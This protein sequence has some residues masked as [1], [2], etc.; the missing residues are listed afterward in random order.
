MA[1]S[2]KRWAG[3]A[4]IGFLM[5][6]FLSACSNSGGLRSASEAVS[7]SAAENPARARA[8]AHTELASQ[9]FQAKNMAVALEEVAIAI[10]SDPDYAPVYN[11]R[12]LIQMYL[13]ENEAAN[14]NFQKAL[15]LAPGD[16]EINNNYGWFLCQTDRERES[17][18]YFIAAVK[19]TLYQTPEKSLVNA[20]LCSLKINDLK[21][22]EDYYQKALAMGRSNQAVLLP[23]AHLEYKKGDFLEARHYLAEY[24]RRSVPSSE[25]LWLG[26]RVE[27]KLDNRSAEADLSTQLRRRFPESK[28]ARDLR[29]GNFE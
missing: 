29:R 22:A 20:G 6:V 27:K 28:E 23:L 25:S 3:R 8:K 2:L 1:W 14:E 16:P 24:H 18:K 26:I 5:L 4:S 12:G 17:F 19:N 7:S 15:S 9:Y 11:I 13:K 21:G 10:N